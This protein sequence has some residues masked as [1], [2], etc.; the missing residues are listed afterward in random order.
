MSSDK[1][2]NAIEFCAG[3]VRWRQDG[4][5]EQLWRINHI[6]PTGAVQKATEEWRLVPELE[7]PAIAEHVRSVKAG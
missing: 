5:L 2:T 6:G 1:N 7:E 4:L 3:E